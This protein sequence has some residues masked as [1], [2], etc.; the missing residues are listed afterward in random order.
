LKFGHEDLELQDKSKKSKEKLSL[1][2]NLIVLF[3]RYSLVILMLFFKVKLQS[4]PMR[5]EIN[6][7]A[8]DVPLEVTKLPP[9][10]QVGIDSLGAIISGFI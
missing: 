1:P 5:P 7:D 10:V 4:N 3:S 2:S 8:I 9:R 6:G